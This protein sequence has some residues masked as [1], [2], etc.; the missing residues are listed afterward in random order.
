MRESAHSLSPSVSSP[1]RP[2]LATLSL[3]FVFTNLTFSA[4]TKVADFVG[5]GCSAPL[6]SPDDRFIAYTTLDRDEIYVVELNDIKPKQSL[7]RVVNTEGVGRRFAFVPGEERIAFRRLAGALPG[8]PDRVVSS[9]YYSYDPTMMSHNNTAILGPYRIENKLF[10]RESLTKPLVSLDGSEW[11]NSVTLDRGKLEISNASG[12][13]TFASKSEEPVEGFEISPDGLWVA[14]VLQ[15]ESIRQVRLIHIPDGNV[16]NLGEGRWPGWSR[17]SNRIVIVRDKSD[18]NYAELVVYD[19]E[20]G[21][22]RSVLG[23]NQFWPNEPA[24]NSNGTKVAFVHEGEIY[25]TEVT[26]F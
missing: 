16:I 20:V 9:S 13:I 4:P 1:R 7:Y 10:I 2:V 12:V 24:L 25:R 17:D 26:G 22:A 21:Q 6:W 19:V 3:I 14:A 11:S 23:L 15:A 5:R 8:A 18:L